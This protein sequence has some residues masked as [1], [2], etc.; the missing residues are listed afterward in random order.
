MISTY[1]GRAKSAATILRDE[2]FKIPGAGWF[3]VVFAPVLLLLFIQLK[4]LPYHSSSVTW[5]HRGALFTDLGLLWLFRFSAM[6]SG[7]SRNQISFT[8]VFAVLTA[9]LLTFSIAIATFPGERLDRNALARA[10]P[11]YG[12]LFGND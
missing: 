7:S 11:I 2:V 9:G 5:F 6:R 1:R 4:F 8:A 12:W 10:T 3:T